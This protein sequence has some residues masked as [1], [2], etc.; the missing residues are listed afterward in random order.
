MGTRYAQ[1]TRWCSTTRSHSAASKRSINTTCEPQQSAEFVWLNGA[2]WYA[3][4]G[5]RMTSSV[6]MCR[7]ACGTFGS[8][9]DGRRSHSSFGRPVLP[10]LVLAFQIVATASG[11]GSSDSDGS[12]SK[13]AGSVA[14]PPIRPRLHSDDELRV[15]LLGELRE[16][17]VGD[18]RRQRDHR[19]AELPGAEAGDLVAGAV[20]QHHRDVVVLIPTPSSARARAMRLAA[21]STSPRVSVWSPIVSAGAS[22][23]RDA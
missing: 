13:S 19:R 4:A 1:C 21:R 17:G 6:F 10:P 12:G 20:R 3:G 2:L 15:A 23:S 8:M 14:R 11:S 9:I 16:L 7:I 5:C 22:G 18:P